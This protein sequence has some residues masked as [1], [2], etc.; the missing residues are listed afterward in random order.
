MHIFEQRCFQAKVHRAIVLSNSFVQVCGYPYK[1]VSIK[2]RYQK[3]YLHPN[4]LSGRLRVKIW[5][6]IS[7]KGSGVY[8]QIYGQSNSGYNE[9]ILDNNDDVCYIQHD[10]YL[11][12]TDG[13]IGV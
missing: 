2:G 13:C 5:G 12:H 4:Y 7:A 1:S 9:E 6:Y 11:V 8:W 3:Q 10:N